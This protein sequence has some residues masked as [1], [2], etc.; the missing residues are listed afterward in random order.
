MLTVVVERNVARLRM[1]MPIIVRTRVDENSAVWRVTI[2]I[3]RS[4]NWIRSVDNIT[5]CHTRCCKKHCQH[6]KQNKYD[7]SHFDNTFL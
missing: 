4:Y 6:K 7:F 1:I 5:I 3:M 2:N